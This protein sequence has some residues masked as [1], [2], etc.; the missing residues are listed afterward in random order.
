[1]SGTQYEDPEDQEASLNVLCLDDQDI[2]NDCLCELWSFASKDKKYKLIVIHTV[3]GFPNLKAQD[4][5]V[6]LHP[7]YK[8]RDEL[9]TD[10]DGFLVHNNAFVVRKALVQTY[11]KRLLSMH[12]AAPKM[13][14]QAHRSLWWPY[15]ARDIKVFSKTCLPCKESELSNPD[16]LILCTPSNSFTWILDRWRV[17]IS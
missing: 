10:S 15:M 5:P 6:Q 17:A 13:L 1:M 9:T 14:A 3:Y 4:V 8:V 12:Q 11:L 7:Y 16:E 2:I